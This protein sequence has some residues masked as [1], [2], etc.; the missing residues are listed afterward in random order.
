M[1]ADL[2]NWYRCKVDKDII[3]EL[4]KKS[5]WNSIK[6]TSNPNYRIDVALPN[7]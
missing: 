6:Q 7:K 3:K 1:H 2:D 4:T 5:D